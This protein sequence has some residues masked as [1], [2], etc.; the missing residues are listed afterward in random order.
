MPTTKRTFDRSMMIFYC[1]PWSTVK[2][3]SCAAMSKNVVVR[4]KM[5]TW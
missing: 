3:L 1:R 2:G 5:S 4:S